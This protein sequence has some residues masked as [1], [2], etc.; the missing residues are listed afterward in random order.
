[1]NLNIFDIFNI[2]LI[3]YIIFFI[4]RHNH[5]L[6]NFSKKTIK[7]KEENNEIIDKQ[8]QEEVD[9]EIINKNLE[10]RD[11]N[12]L[13]NRLTAPEQRH[14]AHL[15]K[16]IEP[17]KINEHTRGEPENFQV[18]GL[19]YREDIDKKYQL[20]GR[21]IYPGAPEREYFIGGKDSGG[22]DYKLPLE[23]N[24]EIFDNSELLNPLD[25]NIYKVKVYNYDKPRYIPYISK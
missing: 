12:V 17:I 21:R 1:M 25:N 8:L 19:L 16:N 20:F 23:T 15:Y 7:I 3:V 6:S 18:V 24:Q 4:F 10:Q 2:F 9:R 13:S 11:E 5:T 14:E 22:L